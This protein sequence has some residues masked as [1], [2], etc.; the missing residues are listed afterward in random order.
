MSGNRIATEFRVGV[1]IDPDV[2]LLNY[3]NINEDEVAQDI[4]NLLAEV[5]EEHLTN[6]ISNTGNRGAVKVA[7]AQPPGVTNHG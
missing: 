6:W 7:V 3:G 2:W 1:D 4:R 5:I